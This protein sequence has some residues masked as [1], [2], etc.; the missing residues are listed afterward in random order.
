MSAPVVEV[1][2]VTSVRFRVSAADQAAFRA[3]SGDDN[4]LHFDDDFAQARGFR[5][6]V[7]F[8]GLIVGA[9]SRLLG[10]QLPGPG[11]VWHSLKLDF[12]G[13]L[14]VDEA[15]E[16]QATVT[17]FTEALGLWRLS[18][19]VAV[20][21]RRIAKGEATAMLPHAAG[22]TRADRAAHSD[23]ADDNG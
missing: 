21:D 2:A 12:R 16:V 8:G 20:G 19:A 15:A 10:N 7:V 11:C 22:A 9:I 18:L 1:G 5:S 14:Y 4:P 17:H 13:P 3:L 6:T 23:G